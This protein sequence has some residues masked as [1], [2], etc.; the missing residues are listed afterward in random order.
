LLD[1][2]YRLYQANQPNHTSVGRL[3]SGVRGEF[4]LPFPNSAVPVPTLL[5]VARL[6]LS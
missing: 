3:V 6:R 5:R 2:A 4:Y 1:N